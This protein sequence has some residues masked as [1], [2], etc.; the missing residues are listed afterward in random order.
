M[1]NCS[2]CQTQFESIRKLSHHIRVHKI[3]LQE[4]YDSYMKNLMKIFV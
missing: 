2:I 4:Y 3:T 1:I